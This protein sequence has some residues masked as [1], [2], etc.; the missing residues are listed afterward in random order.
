MRGDVLTLGMVRDVRLEDDR[1][2]LQML[3]MDFTLDGRAGFIYAM[4]KAV[5]LFHVK[6]KM[7]ELRGAQST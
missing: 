2:A 1:M 7:H 3:P 6:V 4:M 5:Q